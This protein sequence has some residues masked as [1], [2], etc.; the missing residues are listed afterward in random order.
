VPIL[1]PYRERLFA[2]ACFAEDGFVLGGVVAERHNVTHRLVTGLSGGADLGRLDPRRLRATWLKEMARELH[3]REFL[4]A[5]GVSDSKHLFD[6]ISMLASPSG[7]EII[8][9]LGDVGARQA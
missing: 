3:L 4:A 6:V 8:G 2:S 9:A 5:A 1:P 7:D